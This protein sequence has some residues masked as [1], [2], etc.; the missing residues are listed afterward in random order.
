MKRIQSWITLPIKDDWRSLQVSLLVLLHL[1]IRWASGS[2]PV[3]RQ[4]ENQADLAISALL[5]IRIGVLGI[6]VGWR[7]PDFTRKLRVLLL[8][9]CLGNPIWMVFSLLGLP[10]PSTTLIILIVGP[11][12][13]LS[14][15]LQISLSDQRSQQDAEARRNA[16]IARTLEP[17]NDRVD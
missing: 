2:G 5:G 12:S 6:G 9:I 4:I 13:F 3:G 16:T 11:L 10:H 15:L 14:A 17:G 1:F 7:A 8:L